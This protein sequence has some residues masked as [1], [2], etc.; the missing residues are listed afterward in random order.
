MND[1]PFAL[2]APLAVAPATS[3][4]EPTIIAW[5]AEGKGVFSRFFGTVWSATITPIETFSG[6]AQPG[7]V[8]AA[9]RFT[10]LA[11]L[12]GWLPFWLILP[13]LAALP[14]FV[15]VVAMASPEAG[16]VLGRLG[17]GLLCAGVASIPL[18]LFLFSL[19]VEL[20]YGTVL[21]VLSRLLGGTGSLA[22]SLRAGLYTGAIRAWLCIP[23][24]VSWVPLFGMLFHWG[25]RLVMLFWSGFAVYGAAKSIHG[26]PHERALGV[27]FVTPIIVF[28]L[29]I[30]GVLTF[31]FGVAFLVVGSATGV[32]NLVHSVQP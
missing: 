6:L 3:P 30:G 14:M 20:C 22:L 21:F 24:F 23:L 8:F 17:A 19:Y 12:V 1:D 29:A 9:L 4:S 2:P 31:A 18:V 32:M 28:C 13:C 15:G 27:A 7:S 16:D 11:S 25:S 10:L 26:L 5:E